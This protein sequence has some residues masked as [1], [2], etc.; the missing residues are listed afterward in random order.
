[1]PSLEPFAARTVVMVACLLVAGVAP[2]AAVQ[3]DGVGTAVGPAGANA[4]IPASGTVSAPSGESGT[5]SVETFVAPGEEYDRLR[6]ASALAAANRTGRLTPASVGVE[7]T[8]EDE[9]VAYSDVIVHRIALNGSATRLLDRVT[10]RN[11]GSPTESFREL[12]TGGDAEFRYI[13]ASACPPELALNATLD[14]GAM[15]VVPDRENGTL[16]LVLD[17]DRLLYHPLG[18]GEPTTDT[19]VK[20]HNGF[21]FTLYESSGLVAENTTVENSYDVDDASATFGGRHDGLVEVDA[22]RDQAVRGRT[23]L[24]PGNE[25]SVVLRPYTANASAV[26]STATVNRSRSFAPRFDLSNASPGATYRLEA[27]SVAEFPAVR[28]GATLVA[29]GDAT[30]ALVDVENQ[31]TTGTVLYRTSLTTTDGGFVTVR[32]ASGGLVG[33]S[34]YLEPGATVAQPDLSP[35]L[36]ENG[37]VTV[38]AYRDANG[39]REFDDADVPYRANGTVVADTAVVGVESSEEPQTP[40]GTTAS[41]ATPTPKTPGSA[42]TDDGTASETGERD[43]NASAGRTTSPTAPAVPGFGFRQAVVAVAAVVLLRL[44]RR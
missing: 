8:W 30:T 28:R 44:A 32:N 4:C 31:T 35:A 37:T 21:S 34:D 40:T 15:R 12:V 26:A 11:R 17:T 25:V 10:A 41:T 39:N 16:S 5:L 36:A 22:A 13:G 42:T 20:G 7:R 2:S 23:I 14:R 43:P 1:M 27:P 19:R 29:V 33:T 24:A 38:T 3:N 6:N 18:G 9:V